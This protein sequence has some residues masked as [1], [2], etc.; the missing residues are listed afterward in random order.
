MASS[1]KKPPKPPRPPKEDPPGIPPRPKDNRITFYGFPAYIGALRGPTHCG[2]WPDDPNSLNWKEDRLI[3][4]D[5]SKTPSAAQNGEITIA[6][7]QCDDHRTDGGLTQIGP[8]FP[9]GTM[10]GAVWIRDTY[11]NSLGRKQPRHPATNDSHPYELTSIV[12]VDGPFKGRRFYG[13]HA[14]ITDT[15]GP[16]AKVQIWQPGRSRIDGERPF[17]EFWIDLAQD[18]HP[19]DSGAS[20]VDSHLEGPLFING[21]LARSLGLYSPKLPYWLGAELL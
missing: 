2:W 11:W 9:Q 6:E 7:I 20:H 18:T 16:L 17:G 3:P 13:V 12:Y 14:K 5:L 4:T 1:R 21:D 19:V 15:H 10:V 8:R